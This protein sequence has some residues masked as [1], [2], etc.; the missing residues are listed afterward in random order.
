MPPTRVFDKRPRQMV[1]MEG[2]GAAMT[3]GSV[4]ESVAPEWVLKRGDTQLN[5]EVI[6]INNGGTQ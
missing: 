1:V 2:G 3:N 4:C 5:D 6:K